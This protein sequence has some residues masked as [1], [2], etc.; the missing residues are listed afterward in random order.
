MDPM[1]YA[2]LAYEDASLTESR[3]SQDQL[4]LLGEYG[5]VAQ[6]LAM[7]GKL[8]FGDGLK[9]AATATTLRPGTSVPLI[10]DGPIVEGREHLIGIFVIDAVDIDEAIAWAAKMPHASSGT[11][12]VEIRPVGA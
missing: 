3:T 4:A 1:H 6:E 9:S 5:R 7:S 12:G 10:T 2:L 11:G 8:V